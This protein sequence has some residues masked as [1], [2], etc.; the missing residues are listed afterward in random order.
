MKLGVFLSPSV[1]A[2]DAKLCICN[3][4]SISQAG[5]R[6]F[7]SRLLQL[8][9]QTAGK[10]HSMRGAAARQTS[11]FSTESNDSYQYREQVR[12]EL[13]DAHAIVVPAGKYG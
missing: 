4:Q 6:G 13:V 5:R 7:E 11:S 12:F 2:V 1:D 9:S 3:L 8:S 10:T